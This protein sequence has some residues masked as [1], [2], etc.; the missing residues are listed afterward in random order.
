MIKKVRSQKSKVKSVIALMLFVLSASIFFYPLLSSSSSSARAANEYDSDENIAIGII[1]TA[2]T[3]SSYDINVFAT[4]P[5]NFGKNLYKKIYGRIKSE[6]SDMTISR[7]LTRRN[8]SQDELLAIIPGANIGKL[9]KEDSPEAALE[10]AE[11]NARL[12]ELRRSLVEDKEL[13]DLFVEAS[14]DTE[15]TELFSNGDESDSGFDL[16]ADL[17]VIQTIL[18][19]QVESPAGNS[20]PGAPPGSNVVGVSGGGSGNAS[21]PPALTGNSASPGNGNGSGSGGAHANGQSGGAAGGGSGEEPVLCPLNQSFNQA[22]EAAR[23]AE[24]QSAGGAGV[25]AGNSGAAGQANHGGNNAAGAATNQEL[26]EEDAPITP[27]TP[28]DWSRARPCVGPFC[29]RLER[30]FKTESAYLPNENCI[31]CHFEKI[32][33]AFKRTLDHNLVPNKATGNL[34]EAAKCKRGSGG[35]FLGLKW[36]FIL[37]PQPILT[38]PNDDLITKGDFLKNAKEFYEKYYDNPGRCDDGSVGGACKP[39]TSPEAAV[40]ERVLS[41]ISSGTEQTAVINQIRQQVD[42]RKNAIEETM[43]VARLSK[44]AENQAGQYR[45]LMQEMNTMNGFFESFI[46]IFNG[47][48]EDSPDR[49]CTLLRNLPTCS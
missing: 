8:L 15:P 48:S 18:F 31:A 12:A 40:T 46:K 11:V 9:L 17:N 14:A 23:S 26:P 20:G 25:G 5:D 10:P 1:G 39:D 3:S 28:A 37:V 4:S 2:G 6:G 24:Q 49:P 36:N 41:Q 47:I 13:N 16:L 29:L 38:P 35:T 30:V 34:F 21:S 27:E 19:G 33:D 44:E 45:V 7:A 32:N 43:R 42:A 22:V